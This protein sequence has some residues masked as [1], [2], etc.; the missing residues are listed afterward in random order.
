MTTIP[1]KYMD[2]WT[3]G[4]QDIFTKKEQKVKRKKQIGKNKLSKMAKG[5]MDSRVQDIFS[6]KEQNVPKKGANG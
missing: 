6:K 3:I 5:P 4:I 2:Y 1:G